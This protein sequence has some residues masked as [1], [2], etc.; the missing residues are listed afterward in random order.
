M[1]ITPAGSLHQ[2]ASVQAIRCLYSSS[3]RYG[4]ASVASCDASYG[5]FAL[6]PLHQRRH[7]NFP[8]IILAVYYLLAFYY[9]DTKEA[10]KKWEER[11]PFQ[12][13]LP[14]PFPSSLLIPTLFAQHRAKEPKHPIWPN[15]LP[16]IH[17]NF[18]EFF[19][20]MTASVGPPRNFVSYSK[21]FSLRS[22]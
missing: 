16:E 19:E 14:T 15:P 10:T 13:F 6:S 8:P 9:H 18:N 7:T 1:A 2:Q 17:R 20:V 12:R 4:I 21:N 5:R 11:S 3:G 22:G